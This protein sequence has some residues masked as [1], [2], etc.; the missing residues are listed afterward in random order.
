VRRIDEAVNSNH[1]ATTPTLSVIDPRA[2]AIRSV[3]Y[4][5]HPDS[6]EIDLRITRQRFDAPGRLTESWDPRLWG[7]TPKANLAQVYCLSG[8]P[9]L[10]DSVDAG[11]QL[12]LLDQTGLPR[13]F[14][15][16]RGSQRHT[17]YDDQR[18]PVAVT[19]QGYTDAP[20]VVERLIHGGSAPVF[21]AH[22]QCGQKI[23]HDDPTGSQ[24][25]PERGL[26]GAVLREERRFLTDLD[27]PDW[28]GDPDARDEL[29]E[30]QSFITRHTFN[31][32]GELQ[33][34]TDAKGNVRIFAYDVAGKQ[35]E[36]WLQW[37]GAGKSPQRLVGAIHYNAHDQVESETAGNGVVTS[38]VYGADD[39]RLIRLVAQ[40]GNQKTLQDLNYRYDPMGNIVELEDKSQVVTHFNKQQIE[41]INRYRYDSLDQLVEARGWEVSHPSHGPALPE[42]QPTPLDPNQRRSYIQQFEY[43]R[44]G[45]LVTR[46]HSGAPGLSLFTSAL[47]NRSLAQHSDGSL[48][49]EPEIAS[50]FDA[51]GNQLE[52]QRGQAMSWDTRNQL[53]RV[54]LVN[55]ADEPDD[56]ECYRYDRPGHRLRKVHFTQTNRRTLRT[57]VRYLPNLEIHR[58]T[59][60]EEHHVI[61]IEA[62]RNRVRALHWPNAEQKDQLRYPLSDLIG[63]STLELDEEG[64]V[65]TWE[66][67]YPF[68]GT[69][70]WAG[71]S[72]WVAKYKTF[73][74]SG[75]E[76][77]ATGLYYYGYRYYAPWLQR[78]V[79]PDPAGDVSGPNRYVMVGNNPIVFFDPKGLER[80]KREDQNVDLDSSKGDHASAQSE[81]SQ[82]GC[83]NE[84][85][86]VLIHQVAKSHMKKP[87]GPEQIFIL[88]KRDDKYSFTQKETGDHYEIDGLFS[89]VI[90]E[91]DPDKVYVGLKN[92]QL[93][94]KGKPNKKRFHQP[95]FVESHSSLLDGKPVY[96]A[97]DI[98]V[99][100]GELKFWTDGCGH[101]KPTTEHRL[102]NLSDAV[103]KM[104][105]DTKF[106]H[107]DALA[108]SEL[109]EMEYFLRAP[110]LS[111]ESSSSEESS[112][113][114]DDENL[115]YLN[116]QRKKKF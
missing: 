116:A 59:D 83:G 64:G 37:A 38:A 97:G 63:S 33:C 79:A 9:L 78:W 13:S 26:F 35:S 69:A 68:G 110:E 86:P 42:L 108:K 96:F 71:K 29:L 105:L 32:T 106:R 36:V 74:Y 30:G 6:P 104:L 60:G 115:N 109:Q 7:T 82:S 70:C 47:S 5:R 95:F 85:A 113:S 45:N 14:W 100:D 22:N 75:K 19:E 87:A 48:P 77:D 43:D 18:R 4:C 54:T 98:V 41:P 52:L 11:W 92:E 15:D 20:R 28:P 12:S 93:D 23:R 62:A 27:L 73:R 55:R 40:V 34:Q 50:R 80:K 66:H 67:Y 61:S 16:A 10:T 101:Y 81:T 46:H 65:L 57:E 103:K 99:E 91:N 90:P 1:H 114:D 21:A 49:D 89:F 24:C 2:L 76:R 88:T 102:N 72:A 56:Y 25:F 3:G 111:D 94:S 8:Q 84:R 58:Q 44:A 31:P 107:Y 39:G 112:L 51:C 53:S 17:D